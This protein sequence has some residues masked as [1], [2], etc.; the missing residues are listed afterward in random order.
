VQKSE[1]YHG[2][3]WEKQN[4]TIKPVLTANARELSPWMASM[5]K[6]QERFSVKR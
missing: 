5:Q 6:T 2:D 4:K 1:K 3:H